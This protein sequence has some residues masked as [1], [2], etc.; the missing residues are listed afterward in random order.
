[1]RQTITRDQLFEGA[2]VLHDG[3]EKYTAIV[4]SVRRDQVQLVDI[5]GF[6]ESS[7]TYSELKPCNISHYTLR[8]LGFEETEPM[9][10]R[11]A[12]LNAD[13]DLQLSISRKGNAWRL[14]LDANSIYVN[15]VHQ[16][17][18]VVW[19]LTNIMLKPSPVE[20]EEYNL[21]EYDWMD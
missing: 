2:V 20:E 10:T 17:Q 15:S 18:L 4:Q 1:M 6:S 5:Y 9:S 16:L 11:Y 7:T 3:Y 13:D 19:S 14:Q 12:L 8:R 21:E